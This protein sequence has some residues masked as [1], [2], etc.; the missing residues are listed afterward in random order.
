[1]II[2]HDQKTLLAKS[3]RQPKIQV[4]SPLAVRCLESGK[5]SMC[6]NLFPLRNAIVKAPP[7]QQIV[8][9]ILAAFL[10]L[11]RSI[12]SYLIIQKPEML[13]NIIEK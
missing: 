5:N 9:N 12:F 4:S 7:T 8:P 11:R 6:S 1:M 10:K 2:Q 3:N 13:L